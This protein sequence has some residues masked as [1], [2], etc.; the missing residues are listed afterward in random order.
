MVFEHII[1][2]ENHSSDFKIFKPSSPRASNSACGS[3]QKLLR[4]FR[5][6]VKHP[7]NWFLLLV[8]KLYTVLSWCKLSP[9]SRMHDFKLKGEKESLSSQCSANSALAACN[10]NTA[11]QEENKVKT[12]PNNPN[13]K[14]EQHTFPELLLVFPS[15]LLFPERGMHKV[16]WVRWVPTVSRAAWWWQNVDLRQFIVKP[17]NSSAFNPSVVA[18]RKT[19]LMNFWIWKSALTPY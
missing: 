1:L 8:V 17:E 11:S 5:Y 19:K 15:G 13:T 4:H 2:R 7:Q 16:S 9:G 12:K 14:Q 6:S 18:E 10:P 3:L